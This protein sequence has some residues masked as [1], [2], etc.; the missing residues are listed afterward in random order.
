MPE[1]DNVV[2]IDIPVDYCVAVALSTER[3]PIHTRPISGREMIGRKDLRRG[4][5]PFPPRS[6]A[7]YCRRY[8][9]LR[10]ANIFEARRHGA[11]DLA[12]GDLPAC[13]PKPRRDRERIVG[14]VRLT[15]IL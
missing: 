3:M 7:A 13:H 9:K 1:L 6:A 5:S 11:T 12:A 2:P 8:D 4:H 14:R 15:G 10:P